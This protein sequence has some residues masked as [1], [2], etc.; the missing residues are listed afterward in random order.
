MFTRRKLLRTL[1]TAA[2][3][4]LLGSCEKAD[5]PPRYVFPEQ[6]LSVVTTTALAAD[7]IRQAG[8]DAVKVSSL[9][10]PDVNPHLWQ[11]TAADRS[12]IQVGE[13]FVMHGMG[14]EGKFKDDVENLRKSGLFVCVL[15]DCLT[16]ADKIAGDDGKPD[17]HFWMNPELWCRAAVHAA[18]VLGQASPPTTAFFGDNAHEYVTNIN[19]MHRNLLTRFGAVPTRYRYLASSHDTL[20]YLAAVYGV[21]ARSVQTASGEALPEGQA[22]SLGP[23]LKEN[24]VSLMF[25]ESGSDLK[26]LLPR[27]KE[28]QLAVSKVITSLSLGPP[29]S[30]MPGLS[31]EL[32]T[33][34]YAGAQR[35]TCEAI[36]SQLMLH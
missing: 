3:A 34:T 4:G 25:R 16:D 19:V 8:Q 24:E 22:K 6:P 23:W 11:P 26:V 18:E 2:A 17:P 32:D 15:S 28:Y 13:V 27:M 10:P 1:P 31:E 20:R 14:L 30:L 33:G 21:E 36:Y 12:A 35:Y 9:I 5:P 29:H 7:L